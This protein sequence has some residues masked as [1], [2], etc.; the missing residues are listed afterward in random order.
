MRRCARR[1]DPERAQRPRRGKRKGARSPRV[2]GARGRHPRGRAMIAQQ[3]ASRAKLRQFAASLCPGVEATSDAEMSTDGLDGRAGW[4]PKIPRRAMPAPHAIVR[5]NLR[6]DEPDPRHCALRSGPMGQHLWRSV[7]QTP[8]TLRERSAVIAA[9]AAVLS[10][11][12]VCGAS[13]STTGTWPLDAAGVA[14]PAD[15]R[16]ACS[17]EVAPLIPS[18]PTAFTTH[19][20]RGLEHVFA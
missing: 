9:R 6:P 13:A 8:R 11:R 3:T 19:S 16:V 20:G 5:S 4:L 14:R 15:R 18:Q 10:R 2:N 12:I 7:V 17:Q 1:G